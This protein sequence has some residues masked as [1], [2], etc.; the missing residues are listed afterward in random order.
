M[1]LSE[2]QNYPET[3]P[4]ESGP[5][6]PALAVVTVTQSTSTTARS[7]GANFGQP[8]FSPHGEEQAALYDRDPP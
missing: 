3:I 5:G 8:P 6:A 1:R 2:L 7:S 4:D